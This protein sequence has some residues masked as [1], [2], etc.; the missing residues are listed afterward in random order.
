MLFPESEK[1]IKYFPDMAEAVQ[2]V[3]IPVNHTLFKIIA[4]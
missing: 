2:G 1:V 3:E 4:E